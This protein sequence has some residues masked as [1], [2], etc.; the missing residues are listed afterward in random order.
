[1]CEPTHSIV[2]YPL[3]FDDSNLPFGD[4][5]SKADRLKAALGK[6]V[7][8][9][10]KLGDWLHFSRLGSGHDG[11][12]GMVHGRRLHHLPTDTRYEGIWWQREFQVDS[13]VWN[14]NTSY[15]HEAFEAAK[16]YH[17]RSV[18]GNMSLFRRFLEQSMLQSD[19]ASSYADLFLLYVLTSKG[20][21]AVRRKL[22]KV[23][24]KSLGDYGNC[25]GSHQPLPI[26]EKAIKVLMGFTRKR[27]LF[28]PAWA[29]DDLFWSPGCKG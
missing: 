10:K 9:G 25:L 17:Q 14:H 6:A 16:L 20:N 22:D 3:N 18:M 8:W 2:Q 4:N 21:T 13:P 27:D 26:K 15:D 19:R 29:D 7:S 12:L 1:M 24:G 23:F 28:V 5:I 11:A